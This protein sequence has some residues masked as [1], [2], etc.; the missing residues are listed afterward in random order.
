MGERA[1]RMARAAGRSMANVA[2]RSARV[3]HDFAQSDFPP[4]F[5]NRFSHMLYVFTSGIA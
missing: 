1:V 3:R 5:P 4:Q 2:Q